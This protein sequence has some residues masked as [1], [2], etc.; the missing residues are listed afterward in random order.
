[1]R[2]ALFS[3][4]C[5]IRKQYLKIYD[6]QRIQQLIESAIV[7]PDIGKKVE[8]L[9]IIK[10]LAFANAWVRDCLDHVLAFQNE[11][12]ANVK[13]F[14]V[15]FIEACIKQDCSLCPK[16]VLSLN[17]LL[18]NSNTEVIKRSIQ[19]SSQFYISLVKWI[20]SSSEDPAASSENLADI[21]QTWLIWL[22][23]K[24]TICGLLTVANND[25]VRTNCVK[26]METLVMMQTPR[27]KYTESDRELN[28]ID[29]TIQP[30]PV[31]QQSLQTG[32]LPS[33]T[34]LFSP[35]H[36]LVLLTEAK[37]VFEHLVTFHGTMHI[38]SVNL[39][40]AMQSLV[41]LAKQKSQMFMGV[42]IQ[43]LESLHKNL[44]PTLSESQVQS[45]K[46]F[47]KLQLSIMLKHPY[48]MSRYRTQL[49]Q[50][51][52]EVGSSQSEINKVINNFKN[53]F[54][55]SD[56]QSI[57][58]QTSDGD[59][60]KRIKLENNSSTTSPTPIPQQQPQQQ[61]QPAA[62]TKQLNLNKLTQEMTEEERQQMVI[63]SVKKILGEEKRVNIA[64]A[65]LE[66]KK[67]VL[68]AL[69]NEFHDTVCPKII[70]DYI[71]HDLRNRHEIAYAII[72]K[73]F[74]MAVAKAKKRQ[75]QLSEHP[76]LLTKYFDSFHSYIKEAIDWKDPRER[77]FILPKLYSESPYVTDEA[78]DRLETFIKDHPHD[79]NCGFRALI[80]LIEF[81]EDMRQKLLLMLSELA[82][83]DK[84]EIKDGAEKYAKEL[85]ELQKDN[86]MIKL[87]LE[88]ELLT[89]AG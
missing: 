35:E 31:S 36:K 43:A 74:D 13:K 9:Y 53:K 52:H 50:L 68:S 77:D 5:N 30:I 38:S 18:A 64:P 82:K 70:Q 22:Q 78:I 71:F 49:T 60:Q 67:K 27:D 57:S 25:G 1:M 61:Q 26:F 44:P 72:K 33:G 4:A 16:V 83:H 23:I 47:I 51:L 42:V 29:P 79:N 86:E 58:K 7:E 3:T 81:R 8:S 40:A 76:E 89:S 11:R 63:E 10:E 75:L 59:T 73:N 28:I 45:V 34:I 32:L 69:A 41:V 20:S 14:V 39:M 21:E 46:K 66:V 55:T 54:S 56:N 6:M 88:E 80:N 12:H 15:E 65:Q 85:Y 62:R 48:S 24:Q 17:L 2:F 37:Q 87:F 84:S 19:A